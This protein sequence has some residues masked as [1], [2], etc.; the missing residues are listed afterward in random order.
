[1]ISADGLTRRLVAGAAAVVVGSGLAQAVAGTAEAAVPGH[2]GFASADA[3]C[4][5]GMPGRCDR[6]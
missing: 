4:D 5:L 2:W 6:A 1:M 3:V